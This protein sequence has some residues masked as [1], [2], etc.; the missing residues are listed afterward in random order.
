MIAFPS[1]LHF[2]ILFIPLSLLATSWESL[3]NHPKLTDVLFSKCLQYL[4]ICIT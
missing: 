4:K 3:S 2:Q 1:H